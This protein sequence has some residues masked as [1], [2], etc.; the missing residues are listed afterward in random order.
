MDVRDYTGLD[1]RQ[2][3]SEEQNSELSSSNTKM[4]RSRIRN[5]LEN[6]LDKAYQADRVLNS[7]IAAKQTGFQKLPANL[8]T[9]QG[10]KLAM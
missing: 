8:T 4:V 3:T 1:L 5:S 9:K 6:L 7:I 2:H 10:I